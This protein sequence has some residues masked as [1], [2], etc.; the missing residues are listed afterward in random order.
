VD[1]PPFRTIDGQPN[2]SVVFFDATTLDR[3]VRRRGRKIH[4]I[5]GPVLCDGTFF[6]LDGALTYEGG[7]THTVYE[8]FK[9]SGGPRCP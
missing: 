4:Y 1:V 8:R 9:L 7:L 5:E 6:L 2:A 3:T